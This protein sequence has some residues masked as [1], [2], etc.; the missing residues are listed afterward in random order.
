LAIPT[1]VELVLI[2]TISGLIAISVYILYL[3]DK[4]LSRVETLEETI[5]SSQA[6]RS[7]PEDLEA[8]L[9]Q[10]STTFSEQ[11]GAINDVLGSTGKDIDSINSKIAS[12]LKDLSATGEHLVTLERKV[13]ENSKETMRISRDVAAVVRNLEQL[14]KETELLV[15]RQQLTEEF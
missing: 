4:L 13:S 1:T 7:M 15:T 14:E 9:K 2:I 3:V 10:T 12:F 5:S 11:I 6:S 8:A